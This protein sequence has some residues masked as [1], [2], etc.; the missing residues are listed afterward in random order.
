MFGKDNLINTVVQSDSKLIE[1]DEGTKK[2]F[3][4]YIK[5]DYDN[6]RY[7][8][9]IIILI[10]NLSNLAWSVINARGNELF[11]GIVFSVGFL[12]D[13]IL[14]IIVL[15]TEYNS[16]ANIYA[17][18]SKF[19]INLFFFL[20]YLVKTYLIEDYYKGGLIKRNYYIQ[21]IVLF[22]QYLVFI[23]CSSKILIFITYLSFIIILVLANFTIYIPIIE[24]DLSKTIYLSTECSIF[25]IKPNIT[26][27]KSLSLHKDAFITFENFYKE[28]NLKF[29]VINKTNF[30]LL[31]NEQLYENIEI[32]TQNNNNFQN[33]TQSANLF[34]FE[35]INKDVLILLSDYEKNY[36]NAYRKLVYDLMENNL[37][38]LN[39][40]IL[41]NKQ[42]ISK[43]MNFVFLHFKHFKYFNCI[44]LIYLTNLLDT[45]SNNI[46]DEDTLLIKNAM[47]IFK[48]QN[49]FSCLYDSNND[50]GLLEIILSIQALNTKF[51][52]RFYYYS[53]IPE[54]MAALFSFYLMFLCDLL[55]R[56][57][58]EKF[59]QLKN[60][61][62]LKNYFDNML[63]S[64]KFSL[65]SF[66]DNKLISYNDSLIN[67][68]ETNNQNNLF[69]TF[70][71][72]FNG[73]NSI[74]DYFKKFTSNFVKYNTENEEKITLSS[75]INDFNTINNNYNSEDY[76]KTI[77]G[78]TNANENNRFVNLGVFTYE[79]KYFVV[80]IRKFYYDKF[81]Y[82]IDL[83]IDDFTKIK[84]A[85]NEAFENNLKH[86]L[87]SK[88]A[89]EF[90]TPLIIIKN[91]I[92]LHFE[93]KS[94]LSDEK[95]K[96]AKQIINL[97][98]YVSFLINDIIIYTNQ[99]EAGITVDIQEINILEIMNFC[100]D[101]TKSLSGIYR[102]SENRE[103]QLKY[104]NDVENFIVFSDNTRL[105]Q[106]MLNLISNSCKFTKKGFIKI[107]CY[108]Y[109]NNNICLEIKDSGKGLSESQIDDLLNSKKMLKIDTSYKY[110]KM[111][112]GL[113]IRI[114][115]SILEKLSHELKVESI[116]DK[117]TTFK[118]ILKAKKVIKE[119]N[120][121]CFDSKLN[122]SSDE[123]TLNE[124]KDKCYINNF[125]FISDKI[126]AENEHK[127]YNSSK[128]SF[129]TD[130]LI[131]KSKMNNENNLNT[132]NDKFKFQKRIFSDKN[133]NSFKMKKY[134]IDDYDFKKKF[135]VKKFI[136][137]KSLISIQQYHSFGK[138]III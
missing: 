38:F 90:K 64:M 4:N 46:K 85:E 44:Q 129:S 51:E 103:V 49:Y 58:I 17:K 61:E 76:I 35:K 87:F 83:L 109:D 60:S 86:K 67:L 30:L 118:I 55:Y 43:F 69:D 70:N 21:S 77:Y 117:G 18:N 71:D 128:K 108:V 88:L 137:K 8:V 26:F 75:I 78:K 7:L 73:D 81:N 53:F 65:L 3:F 82:I 11:F 52:K 14:L 15:K 24:N 31:N 39:S 89:H 54:I 136:S 32:N 22:F 116:V 56:V 29:D 37:L 59:Y 100:F 9:G 13:L 66:K 48:D 42:K 6:P 127:K 130:L 122:K 74:N 101:I 20:L 45:D 63:N 132:Y 119:E 105:I 120:S 62:T 25:Q 72:N 99:N 114:V 40:K 5:N 91:L 28:H 16:K 47:E 92:E 27:R 50:Y 98:D 96:I 106:V 135:S 138:I 2:E 93:N 113:G 12:L 34:K 41:S 102:C 115:Q 133:V 1:E 123:E 79:D 121:L 95:N 23:E 80:M 68:L 107:S 33:I 19:I 134:S 94:N 97:S 104:D 110:N 57:R 111:G 126:R 112:T 125:D 36:L 10:C 124:I 84:V 131:K